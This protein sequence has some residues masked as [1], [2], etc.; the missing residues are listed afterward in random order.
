[1][2]VYIDPIRT[3][4]SGKWCH[5]TADSLDELHTMA[6]KIGLKRAWFQDH[7]IPHYDLRPS[8]RNQACLYGAVA[9]SSEEMVKRAR[10]VQRESSVSH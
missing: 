1:M 7:S 6:A 2:T 8:K 9:I 10:E 5:M 3:W 4:P